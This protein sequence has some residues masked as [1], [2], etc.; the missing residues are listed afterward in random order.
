MVES[1]IALSPTALASNVAF[2][3]AV[4]E[5]VCR[6]MRISPEQNPFL[7]YTFCHT[8]NGVLGVA[9]PLVQEL[10][11]FNNPPSDALDTPD[12]REQFYTELACIATVGTLT[13]QID[14]HAKNVV[15]GKGA[16]G[17]WHLY[18]VDYDLIDIT[19]AV[20]DCIFGN[21]PMVYGMPPGVGATVGWPFGRAIPDTAVAELY[22]FAR[23]T[24]RS[25]L[26]GMTSEPST[27]FEK[28]LNGNPPSSSRL[29]LDEQGN[30]RPQETVANGEQFLTLLKDCQN[31]A[32]AVY[33]IPSLDLDKLTEDGKEFVGTI[34]AM[35][36][37]PREEIRR[38]YMDATLFGVEGSKLWSGLM[39]EFCKS[40]G[41]INDTQAK[42]T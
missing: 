29:L 9:F 25:M 36:P 19:K 4:S 32:L 13:G 33:Q 6:E 21:F 10:Y 27:D 39:G 23:E 34:R 3:Y 14:L 40:A 24:A 31:G 26:P 5:R 38:G 20:E 7:P 12:K 2:T 37:L 18:V 16:D 15:W 1:G 42:M 41:F 11:D 35:F 30:E 8:Q 17:K 22:D 28:K